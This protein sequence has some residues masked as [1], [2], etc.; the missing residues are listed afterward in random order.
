LLLL[1]V[2]TVACHE[3]NN[4]DRTGVRW[5]DAVVQAVLSGDQEA[6]RG[7][8]RYTSIAC[9]TVPLEIGGPPECLP[10]ESDGTVIDALLVASCEGHYARPDGIDQALTY[11]LAAKPKLYGVYQGSPGTLLPGDYWAVFSVE[12]AEPGE[13]DGKALVIDPYGAI[14]FIDFGCNESPEQLAQRLEQQPS[15]TPAA[16]PAADTGVPEVDA[17]VQAVLSGDQEALRGFVRYA[18]VACSTK[19][20]IGVE[21][22]RPDE[23]DGTVVDALYLA[24]CEGYYV[25]P[26]EIDRSLGYLLARKPKLYGVYQG[27]TRTYLTGGYTAVFSVE[28]PER[29]Q[30]F[31]VELL[32]DDG[33]IVFINFGCAASPEQLAQ[34]LGQQ[35]SPTP[36]ATPDGG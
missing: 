5:V 1:A 8:V 23:P 3:E 27:S 21:P 4:R 9:T 33:A 29:G 15:P 14:V 11:L 2:A 17:V 18:P 7:S 26:D 22:C 20:E 36:V 35:P 12:G 19:S 10:G 34:Y 31:G 25:R 16:T 30:V 28:G 32:I 13:V 24:D 6:L